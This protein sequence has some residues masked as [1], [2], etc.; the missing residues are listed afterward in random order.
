MRTAERFLGQTFQQLEEREVPANVLVSG[1]T[2]YIKA[3]EGDTITINRND[4]PLGAISVSDSVGTIFT[5]LNTS[6]IP[7]HVVVQMA[8]VNNATL[9]TG[10]NATFIGNLTIE[11][12]KSSSNVTFSNNT[13]VFGNLVFKGSVTGQDTFTWGGSSSAMVFG[14]MILNM[15]GGNN[16]LTLRSST[17]HKNVT[18]T[19]GK[20]SDVLLM[21]NTSVGDP[22]RCL[23]T[24]NVNL[25]A[26]SNTLQANSGGLRVHGGLTYVGL[27]GDDTFIS[28]NENVETIGV[29]GHLTLNMGEGTNNVSTDMIS[30]GGNFN[31][32]TGNGS[33]TVRFN[34]DSYIGG[35]YVSYLG[36]GS[37]ST[38]LGV[39]FDN[40][41]IGGN[42][43]YV[44]GT[45]NDQLTYQWGD[46]GG[47]FSANTSHSAGNEFVR[48][49]SSGYAR[50]GGNV[51]VVGG[52]GS[53][54]L[55]IQRSSIGGTLTA[56]LG[57]DFDEVVMDESGVGGATVISTGAGIDWVW[58][59]NVGTAS[60][61]VFSSTVKILTGDG[62]DAVTI[63][64][65]GSRQAIFGNKLF[66]D[67]GTGSDTLT[68]IRRTFWLPG[69]S[70]NCESGSF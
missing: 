12:P 29:G 16:G 39:N 40:V 52:N 54:V 45:G 50:V 10:S 64:N 60:D 3:G 44:G 41:K 42:F 31:L 43:S 51:N 11:G 47:N 35:S 20:D 49:G 19:G 22:F 5:S 28:V 68:C 1:T 4:S 61:M 32:R 63:G 7:K 8:H 17:I 58:L 67:G 30:V 48:I 15:A 25:G 46:I 21:G 23:G 53:Q 33:D 27:T 56:S 24:M 69:S 9:N 2:L 55:S 37:N 6:F 18:I 65:Q 36:S 66:I 70:E 59:S 13:R 57:N 62:N 38:I 26:G 34:D 14:S